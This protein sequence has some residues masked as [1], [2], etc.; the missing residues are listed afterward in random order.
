M[1]RFLT[2]TA[3]G[4]LLQ[5]APALA[6]TQTATEPAQ[7]IGHDAAPSAAMPS[8]PADPT[9]PNAPQVP[10]EVMAPAPSA[11]PPQSSG[12]PKPIQSEHSAE[13]APVTSPF[14]TKQD[15]SELLAANLIG[16]PVL[17]ADNESIGEVTDLITDKDGKIVALLIGAGG[18]LGI[19]EKDL[20]IRYQDITV[21]RD[22][23]DDLIVK[24]NVTKEM[25]AQAPDYETLD[26][27]QMIVGEKSDRQDSSQ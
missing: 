7:A 19:G 12:V 10:P 8:N 9:D 14:L 18:F 13:A 5:F 23:N 16:Q 6:E 24:A 26:E 3:I 21:S 27:Q 2:T 11:T 1:T 25:V 15:Q 4:L 17:D 22:E 20:A